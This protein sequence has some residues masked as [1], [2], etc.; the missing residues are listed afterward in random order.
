MPPVDT[1]ADKLYKLTKD[2]LTKLEIVFPEEIAVTIAIAVCRAMDFYF[3]LPLPDSEEQRNAAAE[4]HDY[5]KTGFPALLQKFYKSKNTDSVSALNPSDNHTEILSDK[6]LI[7]AGKLLVAQQLVQHHWSDLLDILEISP[8]HFLVKHKYKDTAV[9]YL[10]NMSLHQYYTTIYK[11]VAIPILKQL[12]KKE[13]GVLLEMKTLVN[14][15]FTHF[16]TYGTTPEIDRYFDKSAFVNLITSQLYDMF[17]ETAIFGGIA[18]KKYI[19]VLQS[20]IGTGLKH[21]T[22]C[23]ILMQRY[24]DM[25][26][27]N[28]ACIWYD[29]EELIPQYADYLGYT[30]DEIRQIFE[31]FTV[32]AENID[33][34]ITN[35]KSFSP[36]LSR[37]PQLM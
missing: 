22:Y 26:L 9:E 32:N 17:E 3:A 30:E 29:L 27:R 35:Q 25:N 18:Y 23:N 12:K 31:C 20:L 34:H 7:L 5:M 37:L 10:E 13:A 14:R 36:S 6:S 11:Q 21:L 1:A 15:K 28:I 2:S 19:R 16:I 33:F 8:N 4:L 24:P